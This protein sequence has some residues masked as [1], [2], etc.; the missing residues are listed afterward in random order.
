LIP[1]RELPIKTWTFSHHAGGNIL[2]AQTVG[3]AAYNAAI[4]VLQG[5]TSDPTTVTVAI[6]GIANAVAHQDLSLI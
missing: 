2:D 3:D 1:D 4:T 6:T 5:V